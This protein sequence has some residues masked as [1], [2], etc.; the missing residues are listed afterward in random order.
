MQ[1]DSVEGPRADRP[2]PP[3]PA[4]TPLAH[5]LIVDDNAMNL[6]ALRELLQGPGRILVPAAS[7][8]AAVQEVQRRDFALILLD[9]YM[10]G[11]DGF[12]TARLIRQQDR[13]RH[14]PIIF[15]TGAFD[16]S[17]SMFRGYEAGA[18]DYIVKPVVPEVLKSKVAVFLEM[19][20]NRVELMREIAERRQAEA[21]LQQ[22]QESL[23]ALAAR[24]RSVREEEQTRIAREIHD[25]LG[26][27]LTGLKMDLAWLAQH[28]PPSAKPLR[29]KTQEMSGLIDGTIQS[30]RRIASGLRPEVLDEGGL[31]AAI[32]WQVREFQKRTGIRCRITLPDQEPELERDQATAVFRILQ[33]VLTNVARHA[34]A[35]RV[36]VVMTAEPRALQLEVQDNGRGIADSERRSNKS[37]GLLGMRE[38]AL[39]IGGEVD[40]AGLKG[41]GTR[42]ML[43]VP[44]RSEEMGPTPG[45]LEGN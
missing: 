23:R 3:A 34:H 6:M 31:S 38:R 5:I 16:D 4:G 26:Q 41:A 18:V 24:L 39:L 32:E 30:V 10:P 1:R 11:K 13:T 44:R 33:E 45:A 17:V 7:G 12:E 9:A 20:N 36:D 43:S 21:R 42:V 2:V 29:G 25:E 22:S 35:T 37:L 14:I 28:L 15:L 19:Y 40:I 8:D 27:S